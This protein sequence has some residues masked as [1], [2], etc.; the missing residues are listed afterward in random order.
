MKNLIKKLKQDKVIKGKEETILADNATKMMQKIHQ[1]ENGTIIFDS[2][3]YKILDYFWY[4]YSI[5]QHLCFH[6]YQNL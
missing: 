2:M 3:N 5:Q 4:S 6:E 1:L